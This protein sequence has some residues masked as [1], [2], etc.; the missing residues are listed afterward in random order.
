MAKNKVEINGINTSYLKVLTH[1]EMIKLFKDLKNG[2]KECKSILIE[3][4]LKYASRNAIIVDDVLYTGN[5]INRGIKI[6][7]DV[8][9]D[10][11]GVSCIA[12]LGKR[13]AETLEDKNIE[14]VN[15]T[16]Y[17]NILKEALDNNIVD[18][19]E[20]ENLKKI[21]EGKIL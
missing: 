11:A 9:I 14:V 17:K 1:N 3:G 4:N 7:K 2:K 18:K 21:Y 6:L 16:N 15:L 19:K 20:Y 12:T 10:T 8:G 13:V 5:T